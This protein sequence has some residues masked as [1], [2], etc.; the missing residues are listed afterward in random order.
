MALSPHGTSNRAILK[1]PSG[2]I[3]SIQGR[4]KSSP[5]ITRIPSS[6]KAL[7][8]DLALPRCSTH[9]FQPPALLTTFNPLL[10]SLL[11]TP[12]S[13]HYFQPPAPL[14]TFNPLLYSPLTTFSPL[15]TPL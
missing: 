6:D 3:P 11:S 2:A 10:Y 14:T 1:T 15:T 5:R 9:Y 4:T 13:T 8:F 7:A 12:C